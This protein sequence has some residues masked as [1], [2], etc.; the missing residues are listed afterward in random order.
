MPQGRNGQKHPANLIGAAMRG[1]ACP[2][3]DV[4]VHDMKDNVAKRAEALGIRSVPAV[5][6]AL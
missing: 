3:C 4:T 5:V 2:S 1:P 6:T